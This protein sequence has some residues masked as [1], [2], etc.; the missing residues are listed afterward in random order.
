[1][2]TPRAKKRFLCGDLH[3]PQR[4]PPPASSRSVVLDSWRPTTEVPQPSEDS[5]GLQLRSRTR[6]LSRRGPRVHPTRTPSAHRRRRG[7]LQRREF[8][9]CHDLPPQAWWETLDRHRLA[10]R[11][12][13]PWRHPDDAGHLPRGND[14]PQR[15]PRSAGVS[16]RP[17]HHRIRRGGPKEEVPRRHGQ[18]GDPLVPGLLRAQRRLRPRL[19][20][21]R[22]DRRRRRLRHQR[23]EDLDLS[24]PP[25]P[26][27]ST[28]SP[29]PTP[30]RPSTR[31][32]PTSFSI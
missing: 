27:T 30:T 26:T 22:R 5:V 3:E 1:M 20:P 12:R 7:R 6:R 10:H 31:A 4:R 2:Y 29:G 23:P 28:S 15:P 14:L 16:G 19:A 18:P 11:V 9:R 13:R 21:D 25:A 17:R 32:S 24:G 8:R